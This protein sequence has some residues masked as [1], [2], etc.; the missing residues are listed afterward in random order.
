MMHRRPG[1]STFV[2]SASTSVKASPVLPHPADTKF[3]MLSRRTVGDN[4]LQVPGG[5][6]LRSVLNKSEGKGG[7]RA[8]DAEQDDDEFD[9]NEEFQDDEEGIA[10][11]DDMADEE[12]TKVLEV[13]FVCL[14]LCCVGSLSMVANFRLVGYR[15]ESRRR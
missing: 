13:R 2:P 12:E 1:G 6:T 4:R 7:K 10:K 14:V 11:I 5:P 15:N 9:Y 3:K 8:G